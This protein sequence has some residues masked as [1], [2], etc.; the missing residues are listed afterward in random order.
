MPAAGLFVVLGVVPPAGAWARLRELLPVAGCLAVILALA[1]LCADEGP[2]RAAGAVVA[3]R[4]A[5]RGPV[6]LLG[7]V[8]AVA[9]MVTA[10]LILGVTVVLLTPVVLAT[11]SR[12]GPGPAPHRYATAHL[13]NA[14]FRRSFRT[15][16]AA[17]PEHV[18][19]AGEPAPVPWF[20]AG[21]IALA[22]AGFALASFAG[23]ARPGA[24]SR[25][26][27]SW[28]YGPCGAGRPRRSGS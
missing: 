19:E 10:A 16:P 15:D 21:V 28:P 26:R 20:T 12:L 14:V 11:A 25:A 5:G 4:T 27:S 9:S 23:R 8:F 13:A 22:L 1:R 7:G 6:A 24:R 17:A 2:F 3:R 18:P